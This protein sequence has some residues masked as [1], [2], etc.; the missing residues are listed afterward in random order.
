MV[1]RLEGVDVTIHGAKILRGITL[2]VGERRIVG[3]VGRNGAGKTTTLRSIMGLIKAD[4]GTITFARNP[5][6]DQK[7]YTRAGLG[8]GYMPEDRRLVPQL[9]VKENLLVPMWA[10]GIDDTEAK[11]ARVYDMMPIVDRFQSRP[12]T[13]L[14]GGQQKLVAL[15]RALTIGARLLLL[16]E[17]FEGLAPALAHEMGEAIQ[18]SRDEQGVSVLIVESERR[19]IDRIADDI[20]VIERGE[21]VDTPRG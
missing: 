20:L 21:L 5:L 14:S 2:S 18:R 1:L 8:I 16:D 19:L 3:L 6:F 17:P 7:P 15:A 11:L 12:A 13:Q 9:T 10:N 4:A